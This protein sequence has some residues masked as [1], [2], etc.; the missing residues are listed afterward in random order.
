MGCVGYLFNFKGLFV[1]DSKH[2]PE[3]A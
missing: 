1:V 3:D 2:V